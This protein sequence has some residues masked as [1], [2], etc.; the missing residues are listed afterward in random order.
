ME[1]NV[2]ISDLESHW[3][4]TVLENKPK[5]FDFVHQT[6]SRREAARGVGMRLAEILLFRRGS[7]SFENVV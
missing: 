5:K 7:F 2:I 4:S 6:V 1:I 3:S